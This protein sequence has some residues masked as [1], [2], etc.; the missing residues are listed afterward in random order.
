MRPERWLLAAMLLLALAGCVTS[1]G[2]G[3]APEKVN[4]KNAARIHTELGQRYLERGQ[5]KL[6][7]EKLQL[8]LNF[9]DNYA[10]A[11][12]VI[13]AVYARIGEND[14]AEAHY[15]RAE[16]L[17]PKSGDTN[18]NLGVFLC[19][20]GKVD[21][22]LPYFSKATKDPFYDT[23]DIAW[24]NAGRCV[25]K[26]DDYA[27]AEKDYRKAL[28]INPKNADALNQMAMV[29]LHEGKAFQARAYIQRFDALGHPNPA[30]LLLGYKIETR[31][32]NSEGAQ[33]YAK[34]LLA[35]FPDSDQAQSID[36]KPQS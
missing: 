15:R 3:L 28:A 32:G 7:L 4:G 35:K 26:K 14:K 19:R 11:H 20:I 29:L 8:A 5:L 12:T 23:K 6:A 13:A 24:S 2:N 1:G 17:D 31:L 16:Q 22:A 18:N 30:A 34:R 27:A 9:D 25:L 36:T 21:Q 33:N 10:P